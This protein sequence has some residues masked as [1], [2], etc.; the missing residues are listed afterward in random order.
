MVGS[1]SEKNTRNRA[2]NKIASTMR[3]ATQDD[4][5]KQDA[6]QVWLGNTQVGEIGSVPVLK[7]RINDDG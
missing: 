1:L 7:L 6:A 2:G 4:G 5:R 3:C